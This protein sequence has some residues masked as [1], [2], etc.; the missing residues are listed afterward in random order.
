MCSVTCVLRT[1]RTKIKRFTQ[2]LEGEVEAFYGLK[3]GNDWKGC[4]QVLVEVEEEEH[5]L[6]GPLGKAH[7]GYQ[8]LW[9]CLCHWFLSWIHGEGWEELLY[10]VDVLLYPLP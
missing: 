3:A 7:Q 8:G 9:H 1:I 4:P 6:Q 10:S 2:C 5:H